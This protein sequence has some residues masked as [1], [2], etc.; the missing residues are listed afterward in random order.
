M[1]MHDSGDNVHYVR[2]DQRSDVIASLDLLGSMLPTLD[3]HP[4]RWKWAIIA[5]QNAVQ[6]ALVCALADTHGWG[7]FSEKRQKEYL[8]WADGGFVDPVPDDWLAAFP[9]LLNWVTGRGVLSLADPEKKALL[10]LN[11]YRTEFAHFK[12]G[13]WSIEAASLPPLLNVAAK[14]TR[15]LMLN[16]ALVRIHL[17]D[18]QI[19]GIE[20]TA[21]L[22]TQWCESITCRAA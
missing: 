4:L 13:S 3:Q 18:D 19:A 15:D 11:D 9:T 8:K 1:A 22:V 14:A 17:S 21:V 5:A 16:A 7:A 10:K 20:A 2:F 12:P 6:G